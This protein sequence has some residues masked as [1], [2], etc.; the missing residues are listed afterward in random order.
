MRG[1]QD[2]DYIFSHVTDRNIGDLLKTKQRAAEA[3]LNTKRET[4]DGKTGNRKLTRVSRHSVRASQT[5]NFLAH[6]K[7][8]LKIL[9]KWYR[10]RQ[11]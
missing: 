5:E 6:Q 4:G 2:K 3:V 11:Q 9:S 8:S 7:Q 10:M 1:L